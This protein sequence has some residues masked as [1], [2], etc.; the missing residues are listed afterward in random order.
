MDLTL[1]VQKLSGTGGGSGDISLTHEF[2][3]PNETLERQKGRLFI[4]ASV[5]CPKN[6]NLEETAKLFLDSLQEEYYRPSDDT[7]IH[8]IERSLNRSLKIA[9]GVDPNIKITFST[10]LVWNRVLYM[11]YIGKPTVYL[12]R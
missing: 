11:S 10:A 8:T 2:E 9:E 6:I 7:P 12:V 1:K 5:Q 4:T 3:P